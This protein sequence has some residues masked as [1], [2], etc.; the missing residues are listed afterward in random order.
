LLSILDLRVEPMTHPMG[1][2]EFCQYAPPNSSALDGFVACGPRYDPMGPWWCFNHHEEVERLYTRATCTQ[3]AMAIR[4][5]MY[6]QLRDTRGNRRPIAFVND[7]DQDVCTAVWCM[8]NPDATAQIINPLLNRLLTIEDNLDTTAGAYPYAPDMEIIQ[9]MAW[10]FEPYTRFRASGGIS[11]RNASDFRGVI[12]DVYA[13]IGQYMVGRCQRIELDTH[14]RTIF[15]GRGWSA[16]EELGL[17]GRTGAYHDGI[18]AYLSIKERTN[19]AHDVVVGRT[20]P[21]IPFPVASILAR[22]NDIEADVDRRWGGSDM[23]GGSNRANGTMLSVDLLI[24]T[25]ATAVATMF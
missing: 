21:F 7:C 10:I 8:D 11:C 19:G 6:Q 20:S 3:I 16:I 12:E 9:E 18:K 13:R 23:I 22:Y 1:F 24:E 5:G 2:T 25:A 4:S 15:A 14:Y 17:H